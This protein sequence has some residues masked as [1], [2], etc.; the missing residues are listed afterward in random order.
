MLYAVVGLWRLDSDAAREALA[1][2]R[3]EA[4]LLVG[5]AVRGALETPTAAPPPVDPAASRPTIPEPSLNDVWEQAADVIVQ[6][7]DWW[8]HGGDYEQVIR[9]GEAA[10][11]LD[12][13]FVDVYTTNAWLQWSLGRDAE[14]VR[15]LHRVVNAAPRDPEAHFGLGFHYFNTKRYRQAIG[16]L[17]RA[18]QLGGDPRVQRT[19]A[20][21]LE[22]L[23][24]WD[25]ARARWARMVEADGTDGVAKQNLERVEGVLAAHR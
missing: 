7:S 13:R 17:R 3:D 19:Y 1:G 5:P 6:E 14:A 9:C 24:R 21:C 12:P 8:W 23:E 11:F 4:D 22:R 18:V 20:H 15:T 2:Q 10:V 25:E 16:P